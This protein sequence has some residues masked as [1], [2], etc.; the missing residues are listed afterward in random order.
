MS[1][2]ITEKYETI[3]YEETEKPLTILAGRLLTLADATFNDPVQRKAFK[4][5]IKKEI[6]DVIDCYQNIA[7][8]GQQFHGV[9]LEVK[10]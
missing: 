1:K 3:L 10:E 7:F 8:K 4:D 9:P 5:I 6:R 2:E